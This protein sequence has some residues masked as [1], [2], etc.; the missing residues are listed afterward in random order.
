MEEKSIIRK[1]FA[2]GGIMNAGKV[3]FFKKLSRIFT[4]EKLLALVTLCLAALFLLVGCGGGEEETTETTVLADLEAPQI[5][6]IRDYTVSVGDKID[7][8]EGIDV[9]DNA[10]PSPKLRMD[11]NS[12]FSDYPGTYTAIY[13][14]WDASGNESRQTCTVTV[15]E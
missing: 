8:L 14:A 2:A 6:G 9:I 11:T 1:M 15:T 10:D 5:I 7:F 3:S 4:K 12:V 13:I